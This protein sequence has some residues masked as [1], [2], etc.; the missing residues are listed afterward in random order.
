M[1]EREGFTLSP[2]NL[3]VFNGLELA[4]DDPVYQLRV[5]KSSL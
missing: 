5:L 1:A 4:P 2:H 3:N